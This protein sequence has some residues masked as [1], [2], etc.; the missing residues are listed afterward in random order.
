MTE[1][2]C[3]F[4]ATPSQTFDFE[5]VLEGSTV[6]VRQFAIVRLAQC[7][8]TT[9]AEQLSQAAIS[10]LYALLNEITRFGEGSSKHLLSKKNQPPTNS[11]SYALPRKVADLSEAEKRQVCINVL[12]AIIGVAVHLKD[13][14]IISQAFS[15]LMLQRKAYSIPTTASLITGL[16]DLALVSSPT[17]FD[18]VVTVLANYNREFLIVEDKQ[19]WQAI[20]ETQLSLARRLGGRVGLYPLYLNNLLTL[21][22]DNGSKIQRLEG[23]PALT[24]GIDIPLGRRLGCLLPVLQ[25]LL[26]H[27]DFNPQLGP[28]AEMIVS[29]FRDVWFLCVMFGFVS[30]AMWLREFQ[31]ALLVIAQKTPVLVIESATDYMDSDLEYNSVLRAGHTS[32]SVLHHLQHALTDIIPDHASDIKSLSYSQLVFLLTVYHVET[33]RSMMG[34]TCYMLRYFMGGNVVVGPVHACLEAILDL[35]VSDYIRISTVK[36]QHQALDNDIAN[37]IRSL[38]PL[39]CHR[40]HSVHS[41]AQR[42]TDRIVRAFPQVFSRKELVCMLLEL[43]QL[44]WRSC[45]AEFRDQYNPVY[46]FTSARA[47]VTLELSDNYDERQQLCGKFSDAANTWL[48]L[49]IDCCSL[50]VTCILQDYLGDTENSNMILETAHLGRSIAL[51]IGKSGSGDP[52]SI[53]YCPHV[54]RIHIDSSSEFAR[55]FTSKMFHIGGIS[56]I[57]MFS[58]ADPSPGKHVHV[59]Q[60]SQC[61]QQAAAFII[62]EQEVSLDLIR[63]IVRIPVYAFTPESM[64]I[65]INVWNWIIVERTDQ[66]ESL[67]L[68]MLAA[69]TWAKTQRKGLF[70]PVMDIKDPFVDKMTYQPSDGETLRT[71]HRAASLLFTPHEI[72]I[73]FITSH[74]FAIRHKNKHL[75]NLAI[76]LLT[77]SFENAHLMS[78]HP[79]SRLPRFQLV[80]LGLVILK[81]VQL[82]AFAEH[83]LRTLVYDM[84]FSWFELPPCWQYGSWKSLALFELNTLIKVYHLVQQDVLDLSHL[85]SSYILPNM[86]TNK[87]KDDIHRDHEKAKL[88]LLLLLENEIYRMNIWCTPLDEYGLEDER[89]LHSLATTSVE[90][91]LATNDA[92][93]D[94]IRYAWCRKEKMAIRL[95]DRF[96]HPIVAQELNNLIA[97]NSLD[98][99]DVPEALVLLFGDGIQPT[100]KLDLKHLKYWAP[101]PAITAA[102][103]FLPAYGNHPL[104]LQYAMRSLEYY[105]VDIVFFYVPQIVQALRHDEF[106]YVER[107]I[108]KAGQVSSLFAHQIIWNMQA[109]FYVDADKGCERPDPLKPTLDRIIHRLVDSF[110]G[111]DRQFYEREFKFFGEITAISGY[112]KEYIKYGQAEKK[113]MQK[114]RLDEELAKIKVDVGVYLPSNPD[115]YVIDISRTSGKPLQSHAKAPFMATFLIEKQKEPESTAMKLLQ[116][117]SSLSLPDDTLAD[118]AGDQ[119]VP[120]RTTSGDEDDQDTQAYRIWQGAIFKVGDDCRQ[121]VLALQLIAV[122]KNIFAS[123]GLDLY[124][125]PYRVVATEPGR[126]VIDVIP[127]SI[128]R[129][130]LGRE[131]V[132]NMYDY[133]VAKYGG[134]QSIHFQRA[135]NN[136]V[137]SLAA[138]SVISYLL[139]IKDRH[140]GN[141]MLDDAGHIIHIDFGFIFDIAPGG[142][143]FE[144]SPFKLTTEMVRIMG[145]DA[146]Q[147]P[148]QQFSELVVKAYLAS[149]PHAEK[150]MQLVTLMLESGLP[151]F[152]GDT[153]RRMRAR[154]QAGKTERAAAQ[155]MLQCIKDSYENQRTVMYDY[156]QKV[157]NGIPY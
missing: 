25:A 38:L 119:T 89:V 114:K 42:I 86:S 92:W 21:F 156:F 151:C 27:D 35:V 16:V 20:S 73:R 13:E 67:M 96:Q 141:I 72:W 14:K 121:D 70:S 11:T 142:I 1:I 143:T 23:H 129:D 107:Y 82:E 44:L 147:Q 108:M 81:S 99:L 41:L 88:L 154:F 124:V 93:K 45:A 32:S 98:V 131:K 85:I 8:Q 19:I 111:D 43:A 125:Y 155:F 150:I 54:P 105:S 149:R 2:I 37:Q 7:V 64:R 77:R 116:N 36:A 120:T 9:P 76:F 128:S 65:G 153:I 84:A 134:P 127:Q 31:E 49:A 29:L 104:V 15:M 60:I 6:T 17:I 10:I 30:D 24:H 109:N 101:V 148:F 68:E 152:K 83:R 118:S 87:T 117:T 115:G 137:Q 110:D 106:G 144:S 122:F 145:G 18:E 136:F 71:R 102:N 97:N 58:A 5:T 123:V 47:N 79:L 94:V 12:S 50:E 132:N 74:F 59:H 53:K 135:R 55:G 48:L 146:Q 157:T 75:V 138:Y 103:Y 26:G 140:N 52:L 69:W 61:L 46:H 39:C 80:Y 100:A 4:L 130:Q 63:N 57:N 66:Q 51:Q 112:L 133:F 40:L 91:S 78:T 28:P 139:Q 34:N 56:A 95:A 90:K 33:R 22:L 62:S 3:Q 126:G 113:P